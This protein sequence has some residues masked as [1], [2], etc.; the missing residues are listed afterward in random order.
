MS[1]IDQIQ[2]QARQLSPEKQ[3]EALDFIAFLQQRASTSELN[4]LKQKSQINKVFATL[5]KLGTFA[6]IFDPIEWQ[7]QTR[8]DRLLPGSDN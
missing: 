7:K 4:R 5:A 8:M 1:I 2:I 6:D 3:L